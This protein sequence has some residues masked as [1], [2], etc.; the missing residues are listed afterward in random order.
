MARELGRRT[1][2]PVIELDA[3][4]WLNGSAPTPAAQWAERQHEL[5]RQPRWIIDGDLGPYD[6]D[7]GLRLSAADTVIV[8]NFGFLRCAWQPAPRPGTGRLLALG[9]G[10]PSP[11]PPGHSVRDRRARSRRPGKRAAPSSHAPQVRGRRQQGE[12]TDQARPLVIGGPRSAKARPVL[13]CLWLGIPISDF[14]WCGRVEFVN[15][16][17]ILNLV[18]LLTIAL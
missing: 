17:R 2:L 4:F 10:L 6:R 11:Q 14:G 8:L 9:L 13:A 1:D 15:W 16:D 5:V 7:L 3:L 12:A 18:Q